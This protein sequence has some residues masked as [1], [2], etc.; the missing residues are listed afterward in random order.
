MSSETPSE[1]LYDLLTEASLDAVF[2]PRLAANP[3]A[4]DLLVDPRFL[5][6]APDVCRSSTNGPTSIDQVVNY[7]VYGQL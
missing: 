1:E 2:C 3:V 4:A 6:V 7:V 5:C